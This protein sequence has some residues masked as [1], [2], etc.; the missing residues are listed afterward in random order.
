MT[1]ACQVDEIFEPQMRRPSYGV[2]QFFLSDGRFKPRRPKEVVVET[3]LDEAPKLVISS[4]AAPSDALLRS[5]QDAIAR[6][7]EL[8]L[9]TAG[10]DSY[11]G[12]P[13]S[14]AAIAPALKI[15]LHSLLLCRSPRIEANSEGGV[16][17]IWEEADRDLSLSVDGSGRFEL[18][19]QAPDGTVEEPEDRVDFD[20]ARGFVDRLTT[21]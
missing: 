13:L 3:G 2:E 6:F 16:D 14:R 8:K 5:V 4:R 11:G 20:T 15:V 9:L 1:L 21:L 7:Q 19:Y 17:L 12:R 10:W 18:L